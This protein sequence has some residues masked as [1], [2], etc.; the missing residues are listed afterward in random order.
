MKKLVRSFA[1]ATLT[2]TAGGALAQT[3]P[4]KPTVVLVHGAFGDPESWDK[5]IPILQKQG[6][7]V[8]SVSIPLTSLADDVA[9]T[10]R[11]VDRVAGPVILVG[12]SWGGTVIT[13]AGI[14]PRVRSLVYVAGF[15]NA[16][17]QSVNDMSKG[18]P[19]AAGLSALTVDGQ[20][21]ASM[22]AAGFARFF[23][24]RATQAERTL[25]FSVQGPIN[26]KAFGEPVDHA[27]SDGQ[28]DRRSCDACRQRS[29]SDGLASRGRGQDDP[30]RRER[31][32]MT[33]AG[34]RPRRPMHSCMKRIRSWRWSAPIICAI[35]NR[36]RNQG[37]QP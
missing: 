28:A 31:G 3:T 15:A 8:V 34:R 16:V 6:V 35:R 36:T 10:K 14:D 33:R 20:G 23:A 12:H 13:E 1:A 37:V 5:V 27:G 30:G 32:R 4:A 25:M 17:G 7:S 9:A 19:Q 2:L 18:F 21:Y 29:R 26:A 24:P 11:A 22:S